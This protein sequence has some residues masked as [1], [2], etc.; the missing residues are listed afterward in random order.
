MTNDEV[1][2]V[3]LVVLLDP[4]MPNAGSY[5]VRRVLLGRSGREGAARRL[6]E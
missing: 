6:V 4:A 5:A 1:T 3:V 2:G